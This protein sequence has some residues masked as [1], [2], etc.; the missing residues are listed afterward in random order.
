MLSFLAGEWNFI[1]SGWNV[2]KY[3][4]IYVVFGGVLVGG[5]GLGVTKAISN[6]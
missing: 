2:V 5:F 4:L 6:L 3:V 1:D